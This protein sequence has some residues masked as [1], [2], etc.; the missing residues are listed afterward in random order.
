MLGRAMQW[1]VVVAVDTADDVAHAWRG[2]ICP[3]SLL[4]WCSS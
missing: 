1:S 4:V 3:G 2:V